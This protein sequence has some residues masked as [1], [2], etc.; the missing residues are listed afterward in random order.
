MLS[1]ASY[2]SR[3]F[4]SERRRPASSYVEGEMKNSMMIARVISKATMDTGIAII[5]LIILFLFFFNLMAACSALSLA[6]L[7]ALA[8]ASFAA[9][10]ARN[11]S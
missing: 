7:S 8:A 2:A 5:V 11:F 9:V 6:A 10:A 3:Y 1:N 4:F